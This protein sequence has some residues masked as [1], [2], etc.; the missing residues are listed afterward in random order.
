LGFPFEAAWVHQGMA[1]LIILK[2]FGGSLQKLG[3]SGKGFSNHFS[4]FW[5]F[6]S[7]EAHQGKAFFSYLIGFWVSL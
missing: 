3:L 2:A 5:W 1:F 7:K 4:S 6:P